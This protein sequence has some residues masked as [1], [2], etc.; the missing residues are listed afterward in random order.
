MSHIITFKSRLNRSRDNFYI[1]IP[2]AW[3]ED[4]EEFYKKRKKVKVII[5]LR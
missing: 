2:K 4:L 3:N 5:E 1:Y